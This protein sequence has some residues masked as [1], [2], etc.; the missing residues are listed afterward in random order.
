ML[1]FLQTDDLLELTIEDQHL[2]VPFA[3]GLLLINTRPLFGNEAEGDFGFHME[4]PKFKLQQPYINDRFVIDRAVFNATAD[5]S[6]TICLCGM[7]YL[8][9][10][11]LSGAKS[12]YFY[13]FQATKKKI[14]KRPL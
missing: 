9:L 8:N 10:T 13:A 4:I 3:K 2:A 14:C 7:T 11:T 1:L 5:F 12:D 6:P